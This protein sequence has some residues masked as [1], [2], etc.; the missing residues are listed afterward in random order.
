M[1]FID[2]FRTEGLPE[3]SNETEEERQQ[4]FWF[5]DKDQSMA[6]D[7]NMATTPIERDDCRACFRFGN[8]FRFG[9]CNFRQQQLSFVTICSV[10]TSD[11]SQH[12]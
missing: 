7:N 4:R 12:G 6:T 5:S 3:N 9:K 8:I 2:L 1:P 11:F 10:S